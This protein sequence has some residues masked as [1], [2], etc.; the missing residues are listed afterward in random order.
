MKLHY[1][2]IVL[3]S[4]MVAPHT[5]GIQESKMVD[6]GGKFFRGTEKCGKKSKNGSKF[7]WSP[8][9]EK[10]VQE[11]FPDVHVDVEFEC[12]DFDVPLDYDNGYCGGNM[13][14]L[15]LVRRLATDTENRLGS[16]LINPG[17]PGASGV[18]FALYLGAL[19]SEFLGPVLDQYDIVGK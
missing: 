17:G 15:S 3:L 7:N 12:T 18:D 6:R 14:Q 19:G 8:C 2:F 16:L 10:F 13:I 4:V 1:A 9:F 11:N 5:M